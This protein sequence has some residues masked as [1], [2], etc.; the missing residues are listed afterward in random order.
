MLCLTY[1]LVWV[2]FATG[3]KVTSK[4]SSEDIPMPRCAFRNCIV[5]EDCGRDSGLKGNK[6]KLPDEM[7]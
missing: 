2:Y 5:A 1:F 7:H 4:H 6:R 3:G